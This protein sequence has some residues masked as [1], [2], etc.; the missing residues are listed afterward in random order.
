M[1][2]AAAVRDLWQAI[3]DAEG[4]IVATPQL[5]ELFALLNV[6]V[7]GGPQVAV[8]EVHPR[9]SSTA[10]SA[11]RLTD[12]TTRAMFTSLLHGLAQ[13]IDHQ[14][15]NRLIKALRYWRGQLGQLTA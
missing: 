8:P 3:A 5:R 11:G 12:P 15:G 10:G 14:A 6:H 1:S 4:L 9:L 13:A 2:V 7:V